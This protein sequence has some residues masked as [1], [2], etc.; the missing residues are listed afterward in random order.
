MSRHASLKVN[1]LATKNRSVLK[2][3]ER[4]AQL[5]VERRWKEGDD[6]TGLPKTKVHGKVKAKKA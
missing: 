1:T 4:I 3:Q 6:V 5:T 2:R